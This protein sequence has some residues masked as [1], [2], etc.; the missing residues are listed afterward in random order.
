MVT[1]IAGANLSAFPLRRPA[2]AATLPYLIGLDGNARPEGPASPLGA[3][4]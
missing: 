2:T 4:A 3:K 1:P